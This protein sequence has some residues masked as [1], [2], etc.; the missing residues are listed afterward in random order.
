[1]DEFDEALASTA[2]TLALARRVPNRTVTSGAASSLAQI[3]FLR[4]EY[5]EAI[6]WADESLVIAEAIGNITG[7][8]APAAIAL[9]AR[10]ELGRPSEAERYLDLIDQA[11]AAGSTMQ[12]SFRFMADGLL[13]VRDLERAERFVEML[14]DH[15][16]RTGR[17]RDAFT[18]AVLGEL[19]FRLGRDEEAE[20][21]F[22][23]SMALA[24][25]IG[26][27]S[28]FAAAAVG[29]AEL[30]AAH[31]DRRAS[32]HHAERALVVIRSLGLRRYLP[33]VERLLDREAVAV[34]SG[35]AS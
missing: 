19:L 28:T 18:S 13:A 35:S 14:R 6:V 8:P 27:R 1:M 26:L 22:V 34:A 16:A 33:R 4:G 7:F 31:G 5:E 29:A 17:L 9:A 2:E 21:A 11:L 12:T 23:Y 25:S 15:P 10:V 3:R 24:D 20:R 32:L 30:A